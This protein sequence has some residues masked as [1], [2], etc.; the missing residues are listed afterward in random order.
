MFRPENWQQIVD[1]LLEIL[2][3]SDSLLQEETAGNICERHLNMY[4]Y[5]YICYITYLIHI[6]I[7]EYIY[8]YKYYTHIYI[9]YTYIY[10]HT[11]PCTTLAI[12]NLRLARDGRADDRP[13]MQ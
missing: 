12:Q 11:H 6:Y 2:G 5:I 1:E 9:Y 8:I 13:K 3:A 4:E 7:Y 10:I